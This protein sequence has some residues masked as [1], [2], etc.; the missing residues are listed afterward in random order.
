MEEVSIANSAVALWT[1][2]YDGQTVLV[3]HNF[4]ST[5]ASISLSQYK[6][7]NK[8]VSNGTVNANGSSLYL[9]AYSSAVF[10]Q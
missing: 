10:L 7:D 1:M 2:S 8:L 3:A 9:G 5:M 6:L 4:S